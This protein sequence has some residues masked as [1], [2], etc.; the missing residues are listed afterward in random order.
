VILT[1]DQYDPD[2]PEG[3]RSLGT[4]Y[5]GKKDLL[6]IG[7]ILAVLT[8]FLIPVYQHLKSDAEKSTCRN[9]L[10][11]IGAA[12]Q[13]YA[14]GND[15]RFPPIYVQGENE[16]PY[17]EKGYPIVWATTVAPFL[18]VKASFRCP[19]AQN[20]E[21]TL[22]TNHPERGDKPLE[23]TYGMYVGLSSAAV[24]DVSDPDQTILVT[25]TANEGAVNTFNPKPFTLL[26]GTRVPFSGFMVGWNNS[27]SQFDDQT[28][29]VTRLAI[30]GTGDGDFDNPKASFRHGDRIFA[31]RADLSLASL[32]NARD[33]VVKR[34][35][36][37]LQGLWGARSLVRRRD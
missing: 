37:E 1:T 26:D 21:V 9:N 5:L 23:L 10:R 12:I 3:S 22:V 4:Q 18:N 7:G 25:E 8:I 36:F 32:Q 11:S 2:S 14:S 30:Y 13:I 29:S 35:A 20:E 17:L 27:N 28:Q 31:I 19:S 16:S 34:N 33:L 15:D 24:G 6:W